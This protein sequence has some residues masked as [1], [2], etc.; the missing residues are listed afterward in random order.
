MNA[1]LLTAILLAHCA[2]AH[3]AIVYSG[4]LTG[5]AESPGNASPGSGIAV[6]SYD[7]AAHMLTVQIT[8]AGLTGTTA[9][10]HIHCCT[11]V[12]A[13]NSAGVATQLPTFA[14]FPLGVTSGT[15]AMTFDLT[16]TASW[17]P[18][19]VTTSGGGTV[20]GAEA[21]LAAGLGNG[22]AYLNIHSSTFPGGEIRGFLVKD[23]IFANGYEP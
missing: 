16:M 7:A 1:R 12:P 2:G 14:S 13:M 3:A 17:N 21:A 19:F 18:S 10:S 15:Y 4:V 23:V 6:V 5:A 20:A 11:A 9:A 8:F 22:T